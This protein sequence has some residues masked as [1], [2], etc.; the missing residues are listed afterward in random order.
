[1]KTFP[2]ILTCFLI[3][4]APALA[5]SPRITGTAAIVNAS[6]G[7]TYLSLEMPSSPRIDLNG[8][9]LSVTAN[10]LHRL[11]ATADLSYARSSIVSVTGHPAD[12]LTYLVGPVFYPT[13]HGKLQT[14]VRGLFGG[15]RVAGPILFSNGGVASSWVNKPAWALGAGV[16]YRTFGSFSVRAGV[17]YVHTNYFDSSVA[18]RGQNNFRSVVGVVY[19]FGSQRRR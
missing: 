15:A 7:Y 5:Q 13:R 19:D 11:G 4:A 18:I 6:V 3:F 2:R 17:D 14:Y 1:M 8:I 10:F 9:D 12:V 16:E